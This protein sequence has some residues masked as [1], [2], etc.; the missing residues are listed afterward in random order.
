[1]NKPLTSLLLTCFL[2][3]A[4]TIANA[5]KE[6]TYSLGLFGGISSTFSNDEGVSKDPRYQYR[7]NIRTIPVGLHLGLDFKGY[8]F[9]IDPQVTQVGQQLNIIN[10]SGGQVGKRDIQQM[11]FQIPISYKKHIVDL[12]FFKVSWVF[13]I[14][15]AV[16]LSANEIISHDQS[17]LRF[18]SYTFSTLQN[19]PFTTLGYEV[20]YDGVNVPDVRNQEILRKEDFRSFQL[21]GSV[22]LRS[23]WD[24]TDHARISFDLRAN[25]GLWDPRSSIYINRAKNNQTLYE[26]SGNR[27]D[28]VVTLTLGYARYLTIERKTR[29]KKVTP[30]QYYGP[31]RKKPK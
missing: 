2:V 8:G 17:K 21:F 31:K 28:I 23:D 1:M 3:F 25:A 13:G 16:L 5:Q 12:S 19:P 4:F 30:F 15:P 26:V 11:Y 27:R 6:I 14:S 18:P 24:V 29:V 9:M 7:Y 20:E 22:G 10:I